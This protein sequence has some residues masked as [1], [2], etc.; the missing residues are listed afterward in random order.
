MNKLFTKILLL[1]VLIFSLV[2]S[3]SCPNPGMATCAQNPCVSCYC[4]DE[5][6]V[7]VKCIYF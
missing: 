2:K 7:P 3:Q 5:G 4:L 6:R 1:I